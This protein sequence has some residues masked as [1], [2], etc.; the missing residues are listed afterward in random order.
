MNLRACKGALRRENRYRTHQIQRLHHYPIACQHCPHHSIF[1]PLTGYR[2]DLT[3]NASGLPPSFRIF[4][5]I[6]SENGN[7]N[8]MVSGCDLAITPETCINHFRDL[9]NKV[10]RNARSRNIPA[11][12]QPVPKARD[13]FCSRLLCRLLRLAS[14]GCHA[15]SLVA[16]CL[17]PSRAHSTRSRLATRR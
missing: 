7:L 14:F 9:T 8:G 1:A 15:A 13:C 17:R 11:S 3:T 12:Y 5:A 6:T 4:A 10:G 16:P 2:S